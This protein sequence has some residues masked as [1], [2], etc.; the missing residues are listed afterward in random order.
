V[1]PGLTETILVQPA[2]VAVLRAPVAVELALWHGLNVPLLLSGLTIVLGIGIYLWRRTICAGLAA[3]EARIPISGERVYEGALDGLMRL[4][5][6]FTLLLQTGSLTRYLAV[7]FATFGLAVGATLIIGGGIA[8]PAA[9][10]DLPGYEWAV[11]ALIAAGT[12]VTV[13]TSS[14]L[15]AICALSMVGIGLALLFLIYGA[16]DLAMTQL[17]LDTLFVVIM[18]IVLLSLPPLAGAS[19]PRSFHVGHASLSLLAGAMVAVLVYGAAS[20]PI[21]PFVSRFFEARSLSEAHGR[22]VVKIILVDFRALDTFGEITV[23]AVAGLAAFAL[24]RTGRARAAGA[25][26]SLILR[27]AS[28]FLVSLILV[29]SVLLLL[30]GHDAPGGGFIGG[31]IAAIAFVLYSIAHGP[32]E[33]RRTLRTSPRSVA[34]AGIGLALLGMAAALAG[35]PFLSGLWT[36]LGGTSADDGIWVGTPLVFD[37]G[38]YLV[39]V[40]TVLTLVLALEEKA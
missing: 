36:P 6:R 13:L 35:Q 5:R 12:L 19:A 22:N 16:P 7:V 8:P 9:W 3:L 39:I 11:V 15:A 14:R 20:T 25:A 17:L 27:T 18:A 21:D 10:P 33:V 32:G 26:G 1:L 34:L 28:R 37:L 2:V 29:F 30:R 31:L 40:G 38:V 24:L 4:A 23:V